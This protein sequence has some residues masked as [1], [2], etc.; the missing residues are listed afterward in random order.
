MIRKRT[1]TRLA[2][3]AAVATVGLS[4]ST[5]MASADAT[6][7]ANVPGCAGWMQD[8]FMNGHD[9]VQGFAISTM[10]DPCSVVL[11]QSNGGSS[12]DWTATRT[13]AQTDRLIDAGITSFVVVCNGNTG[14][15]ATSQ[16]Y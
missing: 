5:G 9:W 16:S 8:T 10:G 15:C 12:S 3:V 6:F 7:S 4:L 2:A 1:A 11:H 14:R 13:P